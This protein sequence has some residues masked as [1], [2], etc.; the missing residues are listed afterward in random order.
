MK[1]I[2]IILSFILFLYLLFA[3]NILSDTLF[4]IGYKAYE[5]SINSSSSYNSDSKKAEM[6]LRWAH[7]LDP[8]NYKKAY[9][10]AENYKRNIDYLDPDCQK[11]I[12]TYKHAFL[13]FPNDT[14]SFKIANL[15]E[16]SK[17]L[18]EK[19][20][21]ALKYYD[22]AFKLNNKYYDAL[23]YKIIINQTRLF[24]YNATINDLKILITL[25]D[26]H[27][28]DI[29]RLYGDYGVSYI[30]KDFSKKSLY[31]RLNS[32]YEK[33]NKIPV[34]NNTQNTDIYIPECSN[35]DSYYLGI[36]YAR[37]QLGGGLLADCEYL[38]QIA[39]TQTANV[40]YYC[41]CKGVSKW[42]S[43]NGRSY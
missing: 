18:S 39:V 41:F 3:S 25:Y 12:K 34:N 29:H 2:L 30:E 43:D 22:L 37:D 40:D 31:S 17:V 24:N 6:Y 5:P 36:S 35:M 33:L 8:D 10:L 13:L 1:L 20:D 9:F 28:K 16:R 11:A 42:L 4:K 23:N 26:D 21:S 14:V 32:C 38:Y 19:N 15:Y 7:L 27:L